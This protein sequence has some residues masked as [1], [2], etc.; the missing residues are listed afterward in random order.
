M[1]C[2]LFITVSDWLWE[3]IF[4]VVRWDHLTVDDE[5]LERRNDREERNSAS[6]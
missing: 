1:T 2:R 4:G 3:R 5:L 6:A